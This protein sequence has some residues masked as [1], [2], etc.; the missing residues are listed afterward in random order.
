MVCPE[1]SEGPWR[2]AGKGWQEGSSSRGGV[3]SEG[4]ERLWVS[5]GAA[6]IPACA[7]PSGGLASLGLKTSDGSF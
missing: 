2:K 1:C 4:L 6:G 5:L 7:Q 3:G